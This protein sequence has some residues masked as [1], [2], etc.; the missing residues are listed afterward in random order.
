VITYKVR[1][2]TSSHDLVLIMF[3]KEKGWF[4]FEEYK[5]IGYLEE[6]EEYGVESARELPMDVLKAV[7]TARLQEIFK[8]NNREVVTEFEV[9]L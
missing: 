6:G 5:V 3:Y 1:L 4:N 7:V 2:E 9:E 8:A